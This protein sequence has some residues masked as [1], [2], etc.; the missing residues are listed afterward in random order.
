M[1]HRTEG[2]ESDTQREH[3]HGLFD[4]FHGGVGKRQSDR[5]VFGVLVVGEGGAG[6]GEFDTGIVGE[7]DN[8]LS[9]PWQGIQGDK[10]PTP[11]VGPLDDA[12]VGKLLGQR[13]DDHFLFGTQDIS[14]FF[15]VGFEGSLFTEEED[16]AKLVEFVVSDSLDTVVFLE[17]IQVFLAGG[18]AGEPPA[19]E[20]DLG[21]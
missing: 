20:G 4:F 7:R 11:G 5:G 18:D 16:V 6:G 9:T 2:H 13:A 12:E 17:G 14:V 19:G 15:H 8:L 10:V 21:G 3:L 1:Q